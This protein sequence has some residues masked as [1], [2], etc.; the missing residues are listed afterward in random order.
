MKHLV[1]LICLLLAAFAAP[2]FAHEMTN[3]CDKQAAK[4]TDTAKRADFMEV[5][6]EKGA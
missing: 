5:L 3:D 2:S 6:L 4:I 1:A